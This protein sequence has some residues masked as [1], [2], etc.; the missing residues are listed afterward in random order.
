MEST[1]GSFNASHNANISNDS[2]EH[3]L[4]VLATI[5]TPFILVQ[6]LVGLV[7]N[8]LLLTLLVKAMS[9]KTNINIY[10]CS[11]AMNNLLSLFPLLILLVTTATQRWVFGPTACKINQA[12]FYM[13]GILNTLLPVVISRKRYRPVHFTSLSAWKPFSK[14]T[15][16]EVGVIWTFAAVAGVIGLI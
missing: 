7:S 2:A 9:V 1:A 14:R 15:Y 12:V 6:L 5:Y 8:I 16:V 3:P 4:L 10:L 13:T 11:M